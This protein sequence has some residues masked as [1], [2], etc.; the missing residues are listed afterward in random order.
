MDTMKTSS[1]TVGV[2]GAVALML[3]IFLGAFFRSENAIASVAYGNDYIATTTA[4]SAA[5]GSQTGDVLLKTGYG[6]IGSVV[7]TG[8]NTGVVNILNATTTNISLRTGN[9][10]TS[11]IVLAT[12][13]ASA[14]AGTYT[15]DAVF[16]A[17]LLVDLN[18]GNM[19]TTTITYR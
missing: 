13:P 5:Y 19:P 14:A 15:L 2:V 17:G 16:T 18:G 6:S 3:G 1:I 10:A 7:I 11:S 9:T 8:A 12:F 4:A